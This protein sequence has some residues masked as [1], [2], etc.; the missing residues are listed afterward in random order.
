MSYLHILKNFKLKSY[1]HP[2]E[3]EWVEVYTHENKL[4]YC[5]WFDS[6]NT[7]VPST[8]LTYENYLD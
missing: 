7:D 6:N 2:S 4:C 5:V 8:I 3:H 1:I